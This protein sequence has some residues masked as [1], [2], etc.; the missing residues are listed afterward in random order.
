MCER[1]ALTL[2]K[3]ILELSLWNFTTSGKS[4]VSVFPSQDNVQNNDKFS[5]GQCRIKIIVFN[6]VSTL[7]LKLKEIRVGWPYISVCDMVK[8]K[9]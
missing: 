2:Q 4:E 8:N 7:N 9:P 1:E 6:N 3:C 5:K